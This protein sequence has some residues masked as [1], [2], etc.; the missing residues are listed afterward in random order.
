M[1][2]K[3]ALLIGIAAL[4]AAM[5]GLA[6]SVAV[7]GP[8]PLLSS[9]LGGLLADFIPGGDRN[10]SLSLGDTVSPWQLPDLEGNLRVVADPGQATLVNY[11]ASWCAP[12]REELP[13]LADLSRQPGKKVRVVAIALDSLPDAQAFLAAHPQ[14]MDI[15]IE[16]PGGTDSSVLLGNRHGVLPFSALIGANGRLIARKVGAFRSATELDEWV[17]QAHPAP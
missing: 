12:C 16:S 3:S 15:R 14:A 17:A 8:A 7:Y 9:P 5:L 10:G 13:L 1:R 6:A 4:L 11:W 2:W